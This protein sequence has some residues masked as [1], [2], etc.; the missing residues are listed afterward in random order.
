M[1]NPHDK[2]CKFRPKL[3]RIY[4]P[5]LSFYVGE[6]VLTLRYSDS[7]SMFSAAVLV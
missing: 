3:E 1:Q 4:S 7:V 2:G 6:Q 5:S